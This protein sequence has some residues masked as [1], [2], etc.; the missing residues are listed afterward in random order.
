M[1]FGADITSFLRRYPHVV[2]VTDIIQNYSLLLKEIPF[3]DRMIVEITGG[4]TAVGLFNYYNALKKG[5]KYP[6]FSSGSNL[7]FVEHYLFPLIVV[8][9]EQL[10]NAEYCSKLKKLHRKGITV[11]AHNSSVCDLPCFIDK[12][13][14]NCVSMIYTDK[15]CPCG[16]SP[17][18]NWGP[19]KTP[20]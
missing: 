13:L 16:V 9:A 14:G 8:N 19:L 10:L 20:K 7:D 4:D 17:L 5:I 15:W 18:E 6:A 2:L 3:P 12:Y 1:L 11:M